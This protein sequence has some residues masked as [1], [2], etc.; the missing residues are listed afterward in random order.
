MAIQKKFSIESK[1]E[2]LAEAAIGRENEPIASSPINHNRLVLGKTMVCAEKD[3]SRYAIEILRTYGCDSVEELLKGSHSIEN[4]KS[5]WEEIKNQV[6]KKQETITPFLIASPMRALC[7][8]G[9]NNAEDVI[10]KI[11][12]INTKKPVVIPFSLRKILVSESVLAG[13]SYVAHAS[14][15]CVLG[16]MNKANKHV[17]TL[18]PL[19]MWTIMSCTPVQREELL[20]MMP[21]YYG[22]YPKG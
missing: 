6:I 21:P 4:F 3:F 18:K 7:M 16:H 2:L 22:E 1:I 17:Y 20:K 9:P 5:V 11:I 13:L 12:S 15:I 14:S 10:E 8:L 19:A